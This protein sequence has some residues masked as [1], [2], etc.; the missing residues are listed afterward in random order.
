MEFLVLITFL[1]VLALAA[2]LRLTAD[3]RDG[4]D[5][6]TYVGG[7]SSPRNW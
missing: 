5:R 6:R 4:E 1:V 3:S 2:A 7:P